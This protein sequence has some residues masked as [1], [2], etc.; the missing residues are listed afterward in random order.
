MKHLKT[1]LA[2]S[3]LLAAPWG[4][5]ALAHGEGGIK[6]PETPKVSAS[7]DI[8]HTKITTTGKDVVF[9]I[10]V[11]GDAG[12]D[13]PK[14][15]GAFANAEVGAYVWPTSLDSATVGFEA[16]QGILALVATFHPDFD[17]AA[18]GAKNRDR[19]HPH[20]VVLTKDEACGPAALK[21]KDIPEGAKPKLPETWPGVPLLID[22][23]TYPLLIEKDTVEVR[24][25]KALIGAIET[26]S[27]DGVTAALKVNANVHAP[28]LC[29]S[30]VYDIASGNLSLPGKVN[31]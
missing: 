18:K 1:S 9:H 21:V 19:W 8:V 6:A 7:Y 15:I 13:K 11:R 4:G 16:G 23:P 30:G 20:W 10:G 25:P 29:V 28:L 2:V 24:V 12:K 3:A 17:D 31:K 27:F 5:G 22:S 26:A 14:A